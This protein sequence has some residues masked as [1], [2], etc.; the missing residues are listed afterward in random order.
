MGSGNN[1][2]EAHTP[3]LIVSSNYGKTWKLL[4]NCRE[5]MSRLFSRG[6]KAEDLGE[7]IVFTE[8]ACLRINENTG[9]ITELAIT[10]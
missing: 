3:M 1:N 9:K 7:V 4:Q 2:E 5:K 6:V 8:S 10:G